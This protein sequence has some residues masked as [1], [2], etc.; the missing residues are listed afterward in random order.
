VSLELRPT[1]PIDVDE[2]CTRVVERL[3]VQLGKTT[4]FARWARVPGARADDECAGT[5]VWIAP[6]VNEQ[7]FWSPWLQLSV[8]PHAG[9]TQLFGRFSPRPAVWTAFAL[10]YLFLT[11]VAFFGC[12]LGLAQLMIRTHAWGFWPTLGAGG[13]ILILWWV[14]QTGKR[15]ADQQMGTLRD[16]VENAVHAPAID[17]PTAHERAA[18]GGAARSSCLS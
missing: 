5:F 4:L 15:L 18:M 16:A 6:P 9:R 12:M 3:R 1:F 7:R 17:S 11:C 13:L 2:G 8:L 14:S 10:S